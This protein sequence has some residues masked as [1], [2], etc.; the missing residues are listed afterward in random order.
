[1]KSKLAFII[2]AAFAVLAADANDVQMD[3]ATAGEWTMDYDAAVKLA[4]KENLPL[5]LN[6]T[7]SDWCHWCIQIEE[8]VFGKTA[9]QEYAKSNAVLV[10][11]DFPRKSKLPARLAER[12]DRLQVEYG[13]RGYP[14]LVVLDSDGSTLL[15]I[16]GAS[17]EMTPTSFI[18]QFDRT[19]RHSSPRV[20]AYLKTKP[21]NAKAYQAAVNDY[22]QGSR[23]FNNWIKSQ[24]PRTPENEKKFA[25]MVE[26]IQKARAKLNDF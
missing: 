6:F 21:A 23:A 20:A 18:G 16:L 9:W 14:S 4:R 7:G 17:R 11:I 3:G 26:R 13:V 12:N 10:T 5:M 24:P 8:K 2:V 25:A 15:G 1:M 22:K 19:T